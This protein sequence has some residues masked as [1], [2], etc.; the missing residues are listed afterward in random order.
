M[1]CVWVFFLHEWL[2]F[3]C[4]PGVYGGQ[5][6]LSDLLK[7]ELQTIVSLCVNIEN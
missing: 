7:L 4:M 1:L 5:K 6:R 2:C 3:T